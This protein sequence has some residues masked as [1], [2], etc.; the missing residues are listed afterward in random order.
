MGLRELTIDELLLVSGGEGEGNGGDSGG[1]GSSGSGDGQ[2]NG[3]SSS[4][5]GSNGTSTGGD[6][7]GGY[8]DAGL[9]GA[10]F[11]GTLGFLG[12]FMSSNPT[13]N[14]GGALQNG[15]IQGG[16]AAVGGYFTT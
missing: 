12:G 1:T 10:G 6:D 2:G 13:T 9:W 16:L 5:G 15:A 11:L 8:M 14:L 7:E 3:A 4:D